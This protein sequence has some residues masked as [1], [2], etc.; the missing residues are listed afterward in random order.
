MHARIHKLDLFG[1]TIWRLMAT[2][3]GRICGLG[4]M[5]DLDNRQEAEAIAIGHAR[6]NR[7]PLNLIV[8]DDNGQSVQSMTLGEVDA[9]TAIA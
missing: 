8:K 3:D 6:R 7:W 2:Q 5:L 1:R 9:A 4:H